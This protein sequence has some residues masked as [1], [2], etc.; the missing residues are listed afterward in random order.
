MNYEHPEYGLIQFGKHEDKFDAHDE[1]VRFFCL[2]EES[3]EKCGQTNDRIIGGYCIDCMELT[4]HYDTYKKIIINVIKE[5][6]TNKN[7]SEKQYLEKLPCIIPN[8]VLLI[9]K[10]FVLVKTLK[11]I[12]ENKKIEYISRLL[13]SYNL[14]SIFRCHELFDEI[15]IYN[16]VIMDNHMG[17]KMYSMIKND[18]DND[19]NI[20]YVVIKYYWIRSLKEA[21]YERKYINMTLLFDENRYDISDHTLDY[22]SKQLECALL[23][24]KNCSSKRSIIC[25]INQNRVLKSS[26]KMHENIQNTNLSTDLSLDCDLDWKKYYTYKNDV[27]V[28]IYDDMELINDDILFFEDIVAHIKNK[29]NFENGK[30]SL[31]NELTLADMYGACVKCYVNNYE[32]ILDFRKELVDIVERYDLSSYDIHEIIDVL[33]NMRKNIRISTIDPILM[34]R[35]KTKK[36]Y[37]AGI[38]QVLI[39]ILKRKYFN[40]EPPTDEI[41]LFKHYYDEKRFNVNWNDYFHCMLI[42]NEFSKEFALEKFSSEYFIKFK[43]YDFWGKLK[44]GK[45]FCIEIDDYNS[46]NT[47]EGKLN[48]ELKTEICKKR[49]IR[50]FRI[51]IRKFRNCPDKYIFWLNQYNRFKK[52]F[53]EFVND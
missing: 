45:E 4:E 12:M 1:L 16:Y 40:I 41:H 36:K 47:K 43:Y 15:D 52:D 27:G 39:L 51:D 35:E 3:C 32:I 29:Y 22:T 7:E 10:R 5:C 18:N 37:H 17:F 33:D 23:E 42:N 28:Y 8:Q 31:C 19:N 11:K 25:K 38:L 26:I 44:N 21:K 48:D 14:L 34:N 6:K 46:H 2:E 53:L 30:C 9:I 50:L 13:F 20:Q 24:I 49:N